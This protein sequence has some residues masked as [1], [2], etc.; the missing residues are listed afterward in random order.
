MNQ[1][2]SPNFNSRNNSI[3]YNKPINNPKNSSKLPD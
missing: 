3:K 2:N 1:T